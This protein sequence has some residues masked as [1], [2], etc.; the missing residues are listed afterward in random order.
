MGAMRVY[1]AIEVTLIPSR[2]NHGILLLDSV[3]H[4]GIPE[5]SRHVSENLTLMRRRIREQRRRFIV[6]LMSGI[7][8][9]RQPPGERCGVVAHDSRQGIWPD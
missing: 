2:Q 7:L 1:T 4:R 5:L 3:R 8:L 9:S 6:A